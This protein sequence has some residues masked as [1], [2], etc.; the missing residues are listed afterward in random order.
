MCPSRRP[1]HAPGRM[2]VSMWTGVSLKLLT[3][4][5]S[6]SG[7]AL[8]RTGQ[9]VAQSPAA[10][11]VQLRKSVETHK[12]AW[13][14]KTKGLRARKGKRLTHSHCSSALMHTGSPPTSTQR[15]KGH[16]AHTQHRRVFFDVRF[17]FEMPL[18][19]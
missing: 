1:A 17:V 12:G 5:V 2:D 4:K 15:Q 11:S 10:C 19:S 3:V 6:Q 9:R 7:T 13:L 16:C 18:G 8:P 14:M